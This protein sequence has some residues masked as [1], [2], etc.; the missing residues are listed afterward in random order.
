MLIHNSIEKD[1]II[2]ILLDN[3]LFKMPDG[4]QLYEASEH[5]LKKIICTKIDN[6]FPFCSIS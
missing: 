5:E 3:G 6:G 2:D 4:R 1:H